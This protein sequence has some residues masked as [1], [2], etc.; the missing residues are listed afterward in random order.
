MDVQYS[1]LYYIIIKRKYSIIRKILDL[2][3]WSLVSTK[4]IGN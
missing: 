1:I 2:G 3:R 4:I